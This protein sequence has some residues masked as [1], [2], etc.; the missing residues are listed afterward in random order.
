MP[1]EQSSAADYVIISPEYEE[2]RARMQQ[3]TMLIYGQE[4]FANT[5]TLASLPPPSQWAWRRMRGRPA[6]LMVDGLALSLA[7]IGEMMYIDYMPNSWN[8][9]TLKRLSDFIN[10]AQG[11]NRNIW[12]E[13]DFSP[14]EP[15]FRQ[16]YD[17]REVMYGAGEPVFDLSNVAVRDVVMCVCVVKEVD[18][19]V[20]YEMHE[21]HVLASLN[22]S[23]A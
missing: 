2:D 22:N 11:Y 1:T 5:Y 7:V 21:M 17:S 16:V 9:P 13:H 10:P 3:I 6:L 23:P 4:P 18:G 14:S 19:Q 8:G 15:I 20:R 12:V